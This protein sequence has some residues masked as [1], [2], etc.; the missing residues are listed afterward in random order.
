VCASLPGPAEVFVNSQRIGAVTESALPFAADITPL[1]TP[2]NEAVIE[3]TS[4]DPL[5]EVSLEI[6]AG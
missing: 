5:G 3:T 4:G 2:R 6:R 1:L